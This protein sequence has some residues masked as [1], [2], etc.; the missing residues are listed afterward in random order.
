MGFIKEL[1]SFAGKLA[2][3][4]VGGAVE[5]VGE[6]TNNNFIKEVGQGVYQV[7]SKS[8][9]LLGRLAEGT[10]N[11]V[12][13]I[14]SD[15]DL[16]SKGARQFVDAAKETIIGVA[17]GIVTVANK[18]IDTTEAILDDV[19]GIDVDDVDG[20]DVDDTVDFDFNDGGIDVYDDHDDYDVYDDDGY[21]SYGY[22][23]QGYDKAGNDE[24]GY[25]EDMNGA[26]D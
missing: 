15:D 1:G 18:G 14:I 20:I 25:D 19:D 13:G 11:T 7:S 24:F 17:N 26:Y 22:D 16:R 10:V 2:G 5:F 8:G 23:R 6:V 3:G 9:E 4:V 21:D 12:E